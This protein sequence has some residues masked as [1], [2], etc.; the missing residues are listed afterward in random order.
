M[1]ASATEPPYITSIMY[2]EL[3]GANEINCGS[4]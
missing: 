4:L 1:Y 2:V 3:K